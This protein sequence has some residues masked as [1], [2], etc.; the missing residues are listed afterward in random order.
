MEVA[1]VLVALF[2]MPLAIIF[3]VYFVKLVRRASSLANVLEREARCRIRV[4]YEL[5]PPTDPII[6]MTKEQLI[7]RVNELERVRE[8]Q[9][10]E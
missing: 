6:G 5:P 10:W 3:L 7:N 9:G 4:N 2:Y 1:I 8:A